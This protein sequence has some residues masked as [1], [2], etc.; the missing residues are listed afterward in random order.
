MLTFS[1]KGFSETL[2]SRRKA[3]G[4]K[5]AQVAE[6]TGIH[7]SI[8]SAMERGKTKPSPDQLAALAEALGFEPGCLFVKEEAKKESILPS[9]KIAVAG[10]GYVGLSLAVLLAQHNSVTAVD[11][12]PE[13]V[14]KLNG[15]ESPIQDEYI[16]RFLAEAKAG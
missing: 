9:M 7:R 3:L 2:L 14:E 1:A 10:T 11:V 13:K 4:L 6:Q 5:Q 12:I 8:L 15:F 16:E